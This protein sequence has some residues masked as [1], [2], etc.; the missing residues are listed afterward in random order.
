M[1]PK[2]TGAGGAAP[3]D[4]RWVLADDTPKDIGE[5]NYDKYRH[6][7][8]MPGPVLSSKTGK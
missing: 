2:A 5:V 8:A 3:V 7:V 6:A 4:K 1:A